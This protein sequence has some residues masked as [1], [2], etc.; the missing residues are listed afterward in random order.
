LLLNGGVTTASGLT[1]TEADLRAAAGPQSFERGL[2]YLDAVAGLEAIGD[3]WVA[4]VRGSED[5][6]VVLT[7]AAEAAAAG[8]RLRAECDCPHGQEGFFCKHC[9]AVGLTIARSAASVPAQRGLGTGRATSAS[10]V[11]PADLESWLTSQSKDLLLTIVFDHLLED[12]DWRRRLQLRAAG[13]A[14]DLPEIGA[15]ATELLD[16]GAQV[17]Q[18]RFAAQYGYLEGQEAWRYARRIREVTEI[19]SS[20]AGAGHAAEA[21]AIAEAALTA[22]AESGRGASDRAGVIAVAAAEL[23][24]SHQAACRQA[25]ADPSRLAGFLA[26]R[27][28]SGDDV[29]LIDVDEYSGLLG[30]RGLEELRDLVAAAHAARPSGSAERCALADVLAAAG[31]VDALVGLAV[32]DPDGYG[33]GHLRAARVLDQAGRTGEALA[34][35][36]RGLREA[37]EPD[38]GLADFI[39]ARY[40]ATGRIGDAVSLRRERFAARPSVAGYQDLRAAAEEAAAWPAVRP[41]ARGLLRGEGALLIDVLIADNDVDGAWD[42]APGIAT[43]AQWLTLADLV[44]QTRPADALAVYL[45]LIG[46]LRRQAGGG[47]YERIAQLLISARECHGRLGTEAAFAAYVRALRDDQKRKRRLIRILDA[48]RL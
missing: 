38:A 27:L 29:P 21:T 48:H 19:I 8:G 35:A 14:I 42:A 24:E 40:R 17:G 31:D 32:A 25:P 13:A 6:L 23:V 33:R 20:L 41:W 46:T 22:V 45:R 11:R 12:D 1:F 7:V 4:T 5:Y 3:R 43:D 9:V 28:V 39:V 34:V 36:E 2:R 15:L 37:A 26:G 18:Y 10:Q 16:A 30:Q 44:R 47:V